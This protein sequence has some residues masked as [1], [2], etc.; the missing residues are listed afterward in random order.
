MHYSEDIADSSNA[1]IN[2][3]VGKNPLFIFKLP[4]LHSP[5]ISPPNVKFEQPGKMETPLPPLMDV[6]SGQ[7][8]LARRQ[9]LED[10]LD[11]RGPIGVTLP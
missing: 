2:Q 9:L 10:D 11:V 6:H 7:E 4:D 3:P 1:S 8:L 5:Q